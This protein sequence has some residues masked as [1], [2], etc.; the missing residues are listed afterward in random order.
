MLVKVMETKGTSMNNIIFQDD[1][2][3]IDDNI[4]DL[5]FGDIILYQ[6]EKELIAHRFY[7]RFGKS[8]ITAG[9]NCRRFEKILIKDIRGKIT[10]LKKGN[11][12]YKVDENTN[13]RKKYTTFLILFIVLNN[14]TFDSILQKSNN[15]KIK[16][17]QK[18]CRYIYKK[19]REFQIQYLDFSKIQ[20]SNL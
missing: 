1:I 7:V 12:Y 11:N 4:A 13:V 8:V 17:K 19:R 10:L 18:I 15:K 14:L 2:I 5:K 16:T 20:H 3:F 6:T 9:D